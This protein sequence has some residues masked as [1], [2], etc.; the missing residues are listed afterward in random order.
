MPAWAG[1]GASAGQARV[2]APLCGERMRADQ[3]SA[4]PGQSRPRGV[5]AA[6]SALTRVPPGRSEVMRARWRR[7][8]MSGS[9]PAGQP[10]HRPCRP[11]PTFSQPIYFG[12]QEAAARLPEGGLAAAAATLE[13]GL[14]VHQVAGALTAETEATMR[15]L[16]AS[17]RAAL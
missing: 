7:R 3:M 14:R 1:P 2:S 11:R 5:A 12:A 6:E 8:A 15:R 16:A 17:L 13:H 9:G 10:R 4:R